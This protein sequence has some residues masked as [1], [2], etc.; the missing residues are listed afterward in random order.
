MLLNKLD[1]PR[2]KGDQVIKIAYVILHYMAGRDTIEC[3]ESILK[4]TKESEHQTLV[5]MVIVDDETQKI[6]IWKFKINI[7][8]I[9]RS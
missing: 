1:H 5:V 7:T 3:A 6:P 2:N 4:A 8:I 9:A